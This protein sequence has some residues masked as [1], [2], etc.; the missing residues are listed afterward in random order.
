MKVALVDKKKFPQNISKELK[1]YNFKIVK[2]SPQIVISYGG[3]G[4]F[5][6][7]ERLYPKIPKLLIK[8]PKNINSILKKLKNYKK[9][10]LIKLQVKDLLAINDII[11]RNKHQQQALR[12]K[13]KLNN[14]S[15]NKGFIGDGVVISTPYGST[16]YFHSITNTSFK[17]GIGIAFNNTVKK[18]KP[19]ITKDNSKIEFFLKRGTALVSADNNKKTI[20]LKPNSKIIIK[21]SKEKTSI[22]RS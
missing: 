16:G 21:K 17:K 10:A 5:F 7:S 11:I 2:K 9:I 8:D 19:I 15:I 1:K 12:F 3:D 18:Q 4:T 6:I 20:T 13:I 14:K 22:I